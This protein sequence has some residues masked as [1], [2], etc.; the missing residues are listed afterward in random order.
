MA[1]SQ[2]SLQTRPSL[3]IRLRQTHDREAWA[4]FVDTYG[5]LVHGFLRRHGM[6]EADVLDVTQDVLT[7]VAAAIRSF[8]HKRDHSGSFRSWLFTIV[9]NRMTDY[10][11]REGRHQR[12]SGDDGA[13]QILA[14]LPSNNDELE[15]QWNREYLQYLF[16]TVADQVRGD[17]Q[18]TTWQAFWRTAVGQEPLRTVA[19]DLGISLPG[20]SIAKRRVLRRMQEQIM[21]LEGRT[22]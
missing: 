8:E 21:F 16:H 14:Q 2:E 15:E 5:P 3:L 18:E 22:K 6:Q 12:G 13:Q 19:A 7:S 9:R 20:V 10:W 11:R 17:F 1:T 4:Q